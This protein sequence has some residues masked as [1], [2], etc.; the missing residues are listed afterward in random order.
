MK[1]TVRK[2]I[3]RVHSGSGP[4]VRAIAKK[5]FKSGWLLNNRIYQIF[6]LGRVA[7]VDERRHLLKPFINI[8]TILT[9][10][11]RCV[12]CVHGEQSMIGV[13]DDELFRSVVDQ[14]ANMGAKS[15]GLSI[16]G[17]PF[18][19]KKFIERVEYVR[20]HGLSYGL[21]SNG[22]L[23]R[24]DK[25]ERML[26][27]GGFESI[28]FSVN[29]FT[30]ESYE[31]IMPPLNREKVYG[32]INDFL[33]WCRA[34]PGKKPFVRVSCVG[35]EENRAERRDY[36]KYWQS[37]PGVDHVLIAD[38]GDWLG[39]LEAAKKLDENAA[40]RGVA[41]NNWLSPC[42]SL[43]SS[44]F[45]YYD[46]R[47]SPCCEDA[48]SRNLIIGDC[49]EQSLLDIW[50]G[51]AIGGLRDQHRG[52]QRHCHDICGKCQWNQ[53]WIKSP[54]IESGESAESGGEVSPVP[55]AAE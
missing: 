39:E 4:L 12:M 55:V 9:C 3:I 50:T 33:G 16:Y 51:A 25:I 20:G 19:D 1:S 17:E 23:L 43:W 47:V 10:N 22:S 29:G 31:R 8:E 26:D 30:K 42:Q 37:R 11:A 36:V 48:G 13:M 49:R 38:Q 34:H 35:L 24:R 54:E 32:N 15:V 44:L 41:N 2:L 40:T 14:A 28:N 7:R 6:I 45:V 18:A 52:N 53:P 46:G 27:L 5:V 21:F